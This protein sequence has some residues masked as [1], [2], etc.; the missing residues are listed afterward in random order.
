MCP[1]ESRTLP[2][3][4]LE[5]VTGQHQVLRRQEEA[6]EQDRLHGHPVRG[7]RVPRRRRGRRG[8]DPGTSLLPTSSGSSSSSCWK[9]PGSR[10]EMMDNLYFVIMIQM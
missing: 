8:Q 4:R 1:K 9:Y 10:I 6:S 5:E 2:R 7:G 3:L